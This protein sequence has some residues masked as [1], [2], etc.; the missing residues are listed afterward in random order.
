MSRKDDFI[1][2][3]KHEIESVRVPAERIDMYVNKNEFVGNYD[4]A[5]LKTKKTMIMIPSKVMPV[6]KTD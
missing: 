6:S 3:F 4:I 2:S 1:N 5:L